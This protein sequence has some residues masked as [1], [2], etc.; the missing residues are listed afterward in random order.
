LKSKQFG[1][2]IQTARIMHNITFAHIDPSNYEE[3]GLEILGLKRLKEHTLPE[4]EDF[5]IRVIRRGNLL[6]YKEF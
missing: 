3:T 6:D 4:H 1:N 2:F 5:V